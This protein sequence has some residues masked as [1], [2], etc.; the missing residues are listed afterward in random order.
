MLTFSAQR[1]PYASQRQSVFARRGMVA[2]SQPLAAEAGIDIMRRGGNAIDAAIATAAALTVVE[3]TGCG[4]GGDAFALVWVKGQLHGLDASGHAPAALNI[5]AVRASGAEAMPLYGWT[6]V[7]VPGCPA[8]WA[9][10][11]RRFGRLPFA[12][13]LQPAISLAEEGF[14]LSPVV[15]RQWQTAYNDFSAKREPAMQAWFD[16]FLIDGKVPK[17]GELFRNPDQARTLK[18]LAETGCESFYRGAL[19]ARIDEASRQG[20]GYLRQSDLQSYKPRWVEPIS[21][22][23]RGYDVW[24]IPPSGQGLVALMTLQILKGF[25]FDH[26]DSLSTWHRQIEALKLAYSDG[27]HHITDP[28]H[29]RVAVADLLGEAY[30]QR[31]RALIGDTALEPK[32]GDPHASGTVYLATADAEGNMVSF[33]QSNY[34]GFGSGVVVPGCGIA[35][36]N[37]G[38]EFSLDPGH[39]NT[40]QPGK[41]TFHTIIPGFISHNGQPVG[42]FG[43]MGGYMQPQG[44]V[45]MVMNLVDFGLNP[46]AA[47]D[48]PRWQWL[49]GMKVGIEQAASRDLAA[50]LQGMGHQVEVACDSVDYGRGQIIVRDPVSGV[51]CGGTEPR[52]DSHIAV[53]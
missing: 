26:R 1:Y 20:G 27:L 53:C 34:H 8:A 35:L 47:L 21:V 39:A 42:P 43:V 31:R 14:P 24:E 33:I 30:T 49:G 11:S 13:L 37:R 16:I 44:H 4:I 3:P 12:E 40:L 41:K 32:A 15:A 6:P 45:Q 36:Q 23:Y 25:D 10:L 2:A 18:E 5:E 29:M 9:E 19:A 46:Q 48:A 22:N 51:L 52:A 50:A 38:Q 7:T 28:E 17:A